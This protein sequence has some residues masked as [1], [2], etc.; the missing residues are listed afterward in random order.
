M[1]RAGFDYHTDERVAVDDALALGPL[2]KPL[3]VVAGSF[4]VLAEFD[5]T[6]TGHGVASPRLW[7]VPASVIGPGSARTSP[8]ELAG[9]ALVEYRV[10]AA[11]DSAEMHPI[12]VARVLLADSIDVDRYGSRGP[13]LVTRLCAS[14]PCR[15]V[16]HGGGADVAGFLSGFATGTDSFAGAEVTQILAASDARPASGAP[17]PVDLRSVLGPASGIAGA[18]AADRAL[19]R[20]DSGAL[21]ELDEGQTAWFQLLDG[22]TALNVL[23]R[24]V[25]E[26]IGLDEH[27]IGASAV[28]VL[29]GLVALGVAA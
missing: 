21:V 13:L 18:A 28:S 14:V 24:E 20:T 19:I 29:N 1:L 3:S 27:A 23:V 4:P 10:G 6:A 5:P 15:S 9:I 25:A 8:P 16:I 17:V 12:T 11:L 22:Y 2:P 7:H 26:S